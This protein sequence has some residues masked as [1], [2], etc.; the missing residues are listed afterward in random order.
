MRS[1]FCTL[2]FG[3][4]TDTLGVTPLRLRAQSAVKPSASRNENKLVIHLS[5]DLTGLVALFSSRPGKLSRGCVVPLPYDSNIIS[6]TQVGRG[7]ATY[8]GRR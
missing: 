6:Q 4:V 1:I 2:R 8:W 5:Q 7:G 3:G